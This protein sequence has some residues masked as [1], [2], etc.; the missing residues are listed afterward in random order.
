[1]LN[2]F[3]HYAVPVC[4][5]FYWLWFKIIMPQIA[6]YAQTMPINSGRSKLVCSNN[7]IT[8]LCTTS[9]F[10]HQSQT[11]PSRSYH[12]K[13]LSLGA[14]PRHEDEI[15]RTQLVTRPSLRER[16]PVDLRH[17]AQ[18]YLLF[19]RNAQRFLVPIIPKISYASI[20]SPTLALSQHRTPKTN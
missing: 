1:M 14:E 6:Y 10:H 19:P 16:L 4:S 7:C 12:A 9:Q 13:T 20:I 2:F 18:N 8:L 5:K 11:R 3:T 17:Y 15:L